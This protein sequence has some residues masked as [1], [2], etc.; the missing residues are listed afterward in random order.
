MSNLNLPLFQAM[1][2]KNIKF[3]NFELIEF[4]TIPEL[5]NMLD[6][7]FKNIDYENPMGLNHASFLVNTS[8]NKEVINSIENKILKNSIL[9]RAKTEELSCQWLWRIFNS[10]EDPK[11]KLNLLSIIQDEYKHFLMFIYF[12]RKCFPEND[13]IYEYKNIQSSFVTKIENDDSPLMDE[14][15]LFEHFMGEICI[16]QDF[17]YYYKNSNSNL[18]KNFIKKILAD[19][20]RHI[21]CIPSIKN[22]LTN[23]KSY[24]ERI[25]KTIE[26]LHKKGMYIVD[27]LRYRSELKKYKI[28]IE[29]HLEDIKLSNKSI[30]L[31]S[32]LT[33]NLLKMKEEIC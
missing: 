27:Y 25:D 1:Q 7:D 15:I 13:L 12:F 8:I 31:S 17:K 2:E 4:E 21:S 11:L 32:Y 22:Y 3:S 26:F 20:S 9:I 10:I 23:K 6:L 14:Y 19:E 29:N 5:T 30:T 18:F 16:A 28:N 33:T 24:T